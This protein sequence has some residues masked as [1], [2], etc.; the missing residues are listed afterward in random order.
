MAD[1]RN[2]TWGK[3]DV[4]G[5]VYWAPSGTT[6]PTDATTALGEAFVMLGYCSDDGV[7]NENSPETDTIKAWGGDE[8]L[9]IQTAKPDHFGVKLIEPMNVDVL[10]AVYGAQN[11][12]GTLADGITVHANGNEVPSSVWVFNM[13]LKGGG[14]KRIVI[15][16]GD[17]A[18]LSE[19]TYKDDEAVGYDIT[20]NALPGGWTNSTDTHREY[21]KRTS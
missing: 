6:L 14:V 13:K 12:E 9:T 11:V 17:I 3:P 4:G 18:E 10:K 21:I 8:V 16:L 7:T 19:I 15:P 20:I 2:V 1:S 5:G